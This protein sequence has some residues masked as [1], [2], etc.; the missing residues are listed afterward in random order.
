[1]IKGVDVSNHQGAIDW[2]AVKNSGIGFA[3]LR[4]GYGWFNEDNMFRTN[5][6]GCEAVGLDYGAY[7]YSYARNLAEAEIEAQGIINLIKQFNPT[8][9]IVIDMEDADNWKR[10]NGNPSNDM[11]VQICDLICRRIEEAGYYAMIYANLDWFKNRIND[12][13][14]D[15]YD[16]WLAHWGVNQPGMECGMWQYSDSGRVSG[17]SGNVDVN[18][19]YR[20][21]PTII[22]G[23]GKVVVAQE[24]TKPQPVVQY[25]D[26][27]IQSGDTL[28]GIAKKCN[29][30]VYELKALNSG[31]IKNENYIQAGWTIKVPTNAQLIATPI[32]SDIKKGDKVKVVNAVQYN[33]KPFAVYFDSYD[34]IEVNGD[35]VVIGQ[36][37]S[38]TCAINKSNVTKI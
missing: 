3:M 31:L 32:N 20:D 36:G 29:T 19:S 10:N 16:K 26:Y 14:L 17:I 5:A 9:P 22:K 34:V 25:Q 1:M 28:G 21:Y 7:L 4:I 15:R 8:Y 12:R 11:Y 18:Y 35:R 30:T 23:M 33:G 13:R 2:S 27:K 37:N 38:V 6:R 24:E